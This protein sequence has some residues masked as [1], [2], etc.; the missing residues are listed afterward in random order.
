MSVE[1]VHSRIAADRSIGQSV[2]NAADDVHMVALEMRHTLK[3]LE[4]ATNEIGLV[5]RD[6]QRTVRQWA[7]V[8]SELNHTLHVLRNILWGVGIVL[9]L[10]GLVLAKALYVEHKTRP[11]KSQIAPMKIVDTAEDRASKRLATQR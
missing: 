4:P 7:S 5:A 11:D 9:L 1:E 10:L 8:A 2:R 6:A 3:R